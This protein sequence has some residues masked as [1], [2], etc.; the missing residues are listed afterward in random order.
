MKATYRTFE[1][2]F[3][4]L[5]LW[6]Q[7]NL[8][9]MRLKLFDY[10][11]PIVWWYVK[12]ILYV[13]MLLVEITSSRAKKEL[14]SLESSLLSSPMKKVGN[15]RMRSVVATHRNRPWLRI[16]SRNLISS[17]W[18]VSMVDPLWVSLPPPHGSLS[19]SLTLPRVT[20]WVINS[21]LKNSNQIHSTCEFYTHM[22]GVHVFQF[23][24][25]IT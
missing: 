1:P 4:D 16:Q 23:A 13:I 7:K 19:L 18:H 2:R 20:R 5:R 22:F 12:I 17:P 10:S 11:S 21:Y 25:I 24:L 14:T 3:N 6:M 9:V 15:L 8:L